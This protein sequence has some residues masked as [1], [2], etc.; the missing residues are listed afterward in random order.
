MA[1]LAFAELKVSLEL[2]KYF[3]DFTI[4]QPGRAQHALARRCFT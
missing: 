3:S 4:V 2:C 1:L